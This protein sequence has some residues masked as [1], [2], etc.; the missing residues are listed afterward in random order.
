M[1]EVKICV[2]LKHTMHIICFFITILRGY[3][4]LTTMISFYHVCLLAL[5]HT[6]SMHLI[7]FKIIC[8]HHHAHRIV[9]SMKAHLYECLAAC[10]LCFPKPMC[11][12]VSLTT[13]WQLSE[14]KT[15]SRCAVCSKVKH[16]SVNSHRIMSNT[17]HDRTLER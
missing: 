17:R 8:G 3:H 1:F 6:S 11:V 15:I 12:F 7:R 16:A 9:F 2:H 4:T 5:K 10:I 14:S 13:C